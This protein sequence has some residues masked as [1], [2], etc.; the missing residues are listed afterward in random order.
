MDISVDEHNSPVVLQAHRKQGPLPVDGKVTR[1]AT[2][3]RNVLETGQFAR[4]AVKGE[5]DEGVGD[6]ARAVLGIKVG[7]A[8]GAFVS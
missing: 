3:R 8:E 5:V 7:D 4:L 2:T 6:D 1:K